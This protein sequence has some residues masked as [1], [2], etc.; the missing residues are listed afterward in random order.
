[1]YNALI[2]P[3][4]PIDKNSNDKLWKLKLPLRIKVFGWYFWK[5]VILSKDNLSS[6]TDMKVRNAF[7]VIMMRQ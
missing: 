3:E 4:V 5:G 7:F 1:M 2:Q 6:K